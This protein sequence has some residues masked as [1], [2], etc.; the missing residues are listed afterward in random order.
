M[1]RFQTLPSM[2]KTK[3]LLMEEILHQLTGSLTHYLQGFIHPRWCRILSI[4]SMTPFSEA[5][6]VT[7]PF[8]STWKKR[9]K[10]TCHS[11]WVTWPWSNKFN[12]FAAVVVVVVVCGLLFVVCC[13]LFVVCCLL[14]V[15]V[16]VAV[17]VGVG[18]GGG[19]GGGSGS[20]SG[21][22]SS[23]GGGSG[24]VVVVVVAVLVV[25]SSSR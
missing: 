16:V 1:L 25:G 12:Y 23:G 19:G 24:V 21:S 6:T 18:G 9:S 20:G 13:L 7:L 2:K 17:I 3:I 8:G 11:I 4:N 5:M 10:M 22:G 14:V 15:V